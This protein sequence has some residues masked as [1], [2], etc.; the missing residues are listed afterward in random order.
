MM[1][2]PPS[3]SHQEK[4]HGGGPPYP[5][6]G[7]PIGFV[8]QPLYPAPPA[9]S[10]GPTVVV[11]SNPVAGGQPAT[12]VTTVIHLP[13]PPKSSRYSCPSC[14]ADIKTR[15]DHKSGTKTHII[16][17][18]LCLFGLWCCAPI[19]YCTESCKDAYHYCPECGT[20]LGTSARN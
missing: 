11:G 1:D 19:P 9:P 17:L 8:Q 20:Y 5:P 14:K 6:A 2:P 10:Q 16:A 15:V 7:A 12:V 4:M 18:L 3:Y 13:L